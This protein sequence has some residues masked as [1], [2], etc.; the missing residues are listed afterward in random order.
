MSLFKRHEVLAE[1]HRLRKTMKWNSIL[2]IWGDFSP[3]PPTGAVY[4]VQVIPI[5][6]KTSAPSERCKHFDEDLY[7]INDDLEV[8]GIF[9]EIFCD[10]KN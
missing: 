3:E 9:P 7:E 8:I 1:C 4:N 5:L 6:G 2:V 10:L